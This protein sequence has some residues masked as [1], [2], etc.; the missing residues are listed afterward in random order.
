MRVVR[1]STRRRRDGPQRGP[2][3]HHAAR[4]SCRPV[5]VAVCSGFH[6]GRSLVPGSQSI[7]PADG[8]ISDTVGSIIFCEQARQALRGQIVTSGSSSCACQER[9]MRAWRGRQSRKGCHSISSSRACCRGPE[10]RARSEVLDRSRKPSRVDEMRR[11]TEHETVHA[12]TPQYAKYIG[13]T[14]ARCAAA[15]RHAA[16]RAAVCAI[17]KTG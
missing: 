7:W 10:T 17:L 11:P 5:F 4:S 13:W 8:W 1:A 12:R 14:L 16:A 15:L 9:C 6:V 3:P 2:T